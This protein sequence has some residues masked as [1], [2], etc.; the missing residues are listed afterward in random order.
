MLDRSG[1]RVNRLST[2]EFDGPPR[3]AEPL[4]VEGLQDSTWFGQPA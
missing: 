2:A 4:T 3:Q 1:L